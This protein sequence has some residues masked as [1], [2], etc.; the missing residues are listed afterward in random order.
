[1]IFCAFYV[2]YIKDYFSLYNI[3]LKI[4]ENTLL[5]GDINSGCNF[6]L[7]ILSKI[8]KNYEGEILIDDIN[9]NRIKDKDLNLAYIPNTPYLFENKTILENLIYPLKIRKITKKEAILRAKTVI[10]P[11]FFEIFENFI[12]LYEKDQRVFVAR[13][14]K[15]D[16]NSNKNDFENFLKIKV[17]FLDLSTKKIL[18]LLRAKLREPKYIL[19]ENFFENLDDC[20]FD[21]AN[22]IILDFEHSTIIATQSEEQK[23]TA[24]K[25][26]NCI[27]FDAGCIAN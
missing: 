26:F 16:S 5:L 27:K 12:N 21:L 14:N 13:H 25:N 18:T 4:N 10:K 20:Y 3:N 24:Y 8:D 19:I 17:K 22:K 6:L 23:T 1:M 7:R 11:Y 9:L 15:F 2:L